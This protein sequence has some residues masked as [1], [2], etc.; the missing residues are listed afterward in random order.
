MECAFIFSALAL[1]AKPLTYE[2]GCPAF[3]QDFHF[4][5]AA[6][7]YYWFYMFFIWYKRY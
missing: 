6:Y 7:C 1:S 3:S 2:L 4:S 5:G